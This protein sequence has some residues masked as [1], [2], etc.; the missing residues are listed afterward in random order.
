[1]K[2]CQPDE[3]KSFFQVLIC[4]L[5]LENLQ[6]LDSFLTEKTLH[7]LASDELSGL[8]PDLSRSSI[9]LQLFKLAQSFAQHQMC[10]AEEN[11]CDKYSTAFSIDNVE[12]LLIYTSPSETESDPPSRTTLLLNPCDFFRPSANKNGFPNG[13]S[14]STSTTLSSWTGII[15]GD[16]L[17]SSLASVDSFMRASSNGGKEKRLDLRLCD[18]ITRTLVDAGSVDESIDD[19]VKLLELITRENLRRVVLP[20]RLQSD[21][22]SEDIDEGIC[23]RRFARFCG[24]EEAKITGELINSLFQCMEKEFGAGL[25]FEARMALASNARNAQWLTRQRKD[26]FHYDSSIVKLFIQLM[27]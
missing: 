22:E 2:F 25:D 21:V 11:I 27:T 19:V 16:V 23:Q 6:T 18:V 3:C 4:P 26:G 12:S 1:M 7:D 24:V 13:Q 5:A 10:L 14:E 15:L 17:H 20:G 9:L 8:S